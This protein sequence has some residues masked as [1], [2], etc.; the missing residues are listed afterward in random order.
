MGPSQ[1]TSF[2]FKR[3]LIIILCLISGGG[4]MYGQGEA[5][6]DFII[7]EDIS[8]KLA[9][10]QFSILTLSDLLIEDERLETLR[11]EEEVV[12]KKLEENLKLPQKED[13]HQLGFRTLNNVELR[14][15]VEV[16]RL[17]KRKERLLKLSQELE[18]IRTQLL[19]RRMYWLHVDSCLEGKQEAV[20]KKKVLDLLEQLRKVIVR[21]NKKREALWQVANMNDMFLM[22]L[23]NRMEAIHEQRMVLQ[24]ALFVSSEPAIWKLDYGAWSVDDIV[25]S[26]R[27]FF[28]NSLFEAKNYFVTH[29]EEGFVFLCLSI[30]L[31]IIY[32]YRVKEMLKSTQGVAWGG[33]IQAHTISILKHRFYALVL[34]LILVFCVVFSDRPLVFQDLIVLLGIWP[35]NRVMKEILAAK[36][37][38]VLNLFTLLVI[39]YIFLMVSNHP[40]SLFFRINLQFSVVFIF[41]VFIYLLRLLKHEN[42]SRPGLGRLIYFTTYI[43]AILLLVSFFAGLGGFMRLSQMLLLL[44]YANLFEGAVLLVSVIIFA[45]FFIELLQH[46]GARYSVFI[47][48][49]ELWLR[50]KGVV[51]IV[52]I[53]MFLWLLSAL[54]R[55][56]VKDYLWNMFVSLGTYEFVVGSVSFSVGGG[57]LFVLVLYVSVNLSKFIQAILRD[58]VLAHM[59]LGKGLPHTISVLVRY[60]LIC[61]GVVL[62]FA[63]TGL[64][65]DSFTV[66]LGALGVG[67]GFGLQNVF[68][69]LVSGLILLFERPLQ[70]GDVIEVKGLLGKVKSIGIRSSNV[71]TFGG[72]E[73]IVPNGQLISNEVI[74]WT[75]SNQCRRIELMV[76]VSYSSNPLQV[77][78][79]L[80]SVLEKRTDIL[81][82]PEPMI[83]FDKLGDSS[84][85][86]KLMFWTGEF[87]E[88]MYIKSEVLFDVF[89]I[90]AEHNIE[91]PFPQRDIHVKSMFA[92]GEKEI[93]DL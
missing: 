77:R 10:D 47:R 34:L 17:G 23:E 57:V 89:A 49:N 83:L 88:W 11:K 52:F 71:Q 59:S 27:D 36:Y 90:L 20:V 4:W 40:S 15:Q 16:D 31:F 22:E 84:L 68:N 37:G 81:H 63:V 28:T 91:I 53:G 29:T 19:S 51:I 24:Q 8:S 58:D 39:P 26:L 87:E 72:A 14:V 56:Q 32:R 82:K 41:I 42:W 69:N 54:E 62:A 3:M 6:S 85:D 61:I 48:N 66:I 18:G 43:H 55:L 65:M 60:V 79:L 50:K 76:G 38:Q 64:K 13:V 30:L 33:W 2:V 75:L 73:V 74:N 46:E 44:S 25:D 12:I 86:F 80:L 93:N 35:L 92:K 67:I 5:V 9:R 1:Y 78:E 21:A 70:L 45:G 7:T